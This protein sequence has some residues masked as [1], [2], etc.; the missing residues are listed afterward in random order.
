M[1]V[2]SWVWNLKGK[3]AKDFFTVPSQTFSEKRK[4]ER[5][6]DTYMTTWDNI[7]K[8]GQMVMEMMSQVCKAHFSL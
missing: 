6:L 2:L 7:L 4:R 8:W 1:N 3:K 5:Y